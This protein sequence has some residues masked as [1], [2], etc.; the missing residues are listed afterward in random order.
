MGLT[1]DIARGAG[2]VPRCMGGLVLLESQ[3]V[4]LFLAEC[5]RRRVRV[6]GIEGFEVTGGA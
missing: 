3:D 2:L 4:P 6:V 5:E 1:E